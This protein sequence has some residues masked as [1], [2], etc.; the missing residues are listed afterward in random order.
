MYAANHVRLGPVAIKFF[1]NN[2]AARRARFDDEVKVATTRLKGSPRVLP[3][4]EAWLPAQDSGVIPWYIMP[5]AEPIRKALPNED[6]RAMLPAFIELADGLAELHQLGVAH[7]DIK[8][9]NLFRFDG[10]YRYGDF[11]IAAFPERS[12]VTKIDEPMGPAT[13]LAPEMEANAADADPYLADVY[14]LAKTIWALMLGEKFAFSGQYSPTGTEQL[15]RSE[16]AKQLFLEPLEALLVESTSSRPEARPTA[17]RFSARLKEVASLQYDLGKANPLQW[18]LANREAVAG[19]GFTRAEWTNPADIAEIIGLLSRHRGMNHCFF[20]EGGGQ[21]VSGASLREGGRMVAIHVP[22]GGADYLVCPAKLTLERFPNHPTFA[23][24]VLTVI[25]TERLTDNPRYL[26][27]P[28]ERLRSLGDYD[29][30]VDDHD[31]DEPRFAH[32]GTACE[33]RFKK[34]LFVLAPTH[35]VFNRVD[36]YLGTAEKLGLEGLRSSISGLLEA[37][38]APATPARALVPFVRL[39]G[40]ASTRVPFRPKHLSMALVWE[41]LD[42]DDAL[43]AA[44][45]RSNLGMDYREYALNRESL[46][47]PNP[48]Q[49]TAQELLA[50]LTAAQKGEYMAMVEVAKNTASPAEFDDRA[51]V[52][53]RAS[54][55]D[56]YFF[57][58]MGNGYMR[59]CLRK[60]GLNVS[61]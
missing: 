10:T 22:E 36:D 8:P 54:N 57:E 42:A 12:G 16:N 15:K 32:L 53:A 20:P 38:L 14:S 45:P 39:Q 59:E 4:I 31:A 55:P 37:S 40:N 41:L 19:Q 48:L 28:A 33:R 29:Y 56:Y 34:G 52:Q 18:E 5:R 17:A 21:H 3:V 61:N 27:G 24:A 1:L 44:R 43:L 23:Y 2:K 47:K 6:W 60:F 7:R 46:R 49:V 13:Y 9:E 58:K 35:G 11:G 26:Q 51:N 25:A 50:R 30:L